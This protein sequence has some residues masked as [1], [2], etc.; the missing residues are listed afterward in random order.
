MTQQVRVPAQLP[1]FLGNAFL[2]AFNPL[3]FGL[4][5]N[6]SPSRYR[7]R[8]GRDTGFLSIALASS[9]FVFCERH[10][11]LKIRRSGFR[12]LES[13]SGRA[14][15]NNPE[16][17]AF[18]FCNYDRILEQSTCRAGQQ[19]KADAVSF[20]IPLRTLAAQRNFAYVVPESIYVFG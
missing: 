9:K 19:Q 13:L 11:L 14:W 10:L 7:Y 4:I 17:R 15:F 6:P 2:E 12:Y 16:I 8:L 1:E 20:L 5:A 18:S 3:T